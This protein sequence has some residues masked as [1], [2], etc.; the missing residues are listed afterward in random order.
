MIKNQRN[1]HKRKREK[2][3]G[4]HSKWPLLP[5]HFMGEKKLSP[6]LSPYGRANKVSS[7]SLLC[8]NKAFNWLGCR[9]RA[10]QVHNQAP[11]YQ[12]LIASHNPHPAISPKNITQMP[13]RTLTAFRDPNFELF[14]EW[15]RRICKGPSFVRGHLLCVWMIFWGKRVKTQCSPLPK[16]SVPGMA[17]WG[18]G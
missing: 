17:Y 12:N 14:L 15:S 6:S 3:T 2:T 9:A 7:P 11:H 13:S 10:R 16:N 1:R 8:M 5:G 18:W 4:R